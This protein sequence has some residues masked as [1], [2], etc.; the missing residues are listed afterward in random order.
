MK[1]R[2]TLPVLV[3]LIVVCGVGGFLTR[4]QLDGKL[5]LPNIPLPALGAPECVARADGEVRL[6]PEQMA[7]AATIAA[8]GIS[9]NV[10]DR[11]V[12]VALAT[13]LQE[14]KLRNLEHLGDGNDHDSLGLFQQRPSQGWGTAKQI[15]DPRHA[16]RRFY[17]SLVKVKGWQKM[18]VTDA[19]Q[20]V[21]RSAY[22]EAYEKWADD[23]T[24]LAK[25]LTGQQAGGVTCDTY[26]EDAPGDAATSKVL[27]DRMKA[28]FGTKAK[29]VTFEGTA[30]RVPAAN[31]KAGW[32]FAHWLVANAPLTGVTRVTYADQQW[33][34]GD[35]AWSSAEKVAEQVVAEAVAGG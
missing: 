34:A 8:V 7:N 27:A 19:A 29:G 25:V 4:Q 12:V 13:A 15:M 31:S 2:Q 21:Q 23:A 6:D 16:S 5:D 20:R 30:V 35:R 14:S 9:R 33:S 26:G 32:Q 3:I 1:G 18:R 22:P 28:D 11:A 24:V 10:P 17:T